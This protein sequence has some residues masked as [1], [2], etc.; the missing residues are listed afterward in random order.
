[1]LRYAANYAYTE[2][3]AS[4][5]DSYTQVSEFAAINRELK[6]ADQSVS[7]FIWFDKHFQEK[8]D[9]Y[10]TTFEDSLIQYEKYSLYNKY[11]HP[12]SKYSSIASTYNSHLKYNESRLKQGKSSKNDTTTFAQKS[13]V[14]DVSRLVAILV[15]SDRDDEAS[16]IIQKAR[17]ELNTPEFNQSLESALEGRLPEPPFK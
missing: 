6:R 9:A 4:P 8:A 14:H 1:L 15:L 16:L 7:L 10:L 12:G 17:L 5:T 13:F 11:L 3:I 2:I